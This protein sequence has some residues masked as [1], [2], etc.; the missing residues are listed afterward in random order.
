MT[1][2][3]RQMTHDNEANLPATKA[4]FQQLIEGIEVDGHQAIRPTFRVPSLVPAVRNLSG[5]VVFGVSI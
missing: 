2:L 5:L 4:L 3:A 1:A